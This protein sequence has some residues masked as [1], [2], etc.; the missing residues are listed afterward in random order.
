MKELNIPWCNE[1]RP[2]F[3]RADVMTYK[4]FKTGEIVFVSRNKEAPLTDEE[5]E[6]ITTAYAICSLTPVRFENKI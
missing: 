6:V 3:E 5:K 4:D 1:L 2:I